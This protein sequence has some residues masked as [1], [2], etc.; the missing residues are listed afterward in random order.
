[1]VIMVRGVIKVREW[2]EA[3]RFRVREKTFGNGQIERRIRYGQLKRERIKRKGK[4][5]VLLWLK[6]QLDQTVLKLKSSF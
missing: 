2:V 1:M 4:L 3:K 6:N 5:V